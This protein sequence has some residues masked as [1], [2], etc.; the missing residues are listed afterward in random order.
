MYSWTIAWIFRPRCFTGAEIEF[1]ELT[2]NE[3][4]DIVTGEQGQ[5]KKKLGSNFSKVAQPQVNL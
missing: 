4:G 1:Y 2:D 5:Q 3:D